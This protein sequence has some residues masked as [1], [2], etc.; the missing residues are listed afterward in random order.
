MPVKAA[1]SMIL[2]TTLWLPVWTRQSPPAQQSPQMK[3]EC[4]DL[5]A[6][7][8]YIAADEKVVD[9]KACH[10]VSTAK[11]IPQPRGPQ[12]FSDGA[13]QFTYPAEYEIGT[14]DSGGGLCSFESEIACVVFPAGR[15]R[16]TTFAGAS[17]DESQIQE[18]KTKAQCLEFSDFYVAGKDPLKNINHV[19][20][21]HRTAASAA[22]GTVTEIDAYRAF[23]EGKC[24]EL[25][26]NIAATHIQ[27]YDPGAIQEFT[28]ADEAQ[29]RKELTAILESFEF[30]K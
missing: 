20:F 22:M 15:F 8:Y 11:I 26:I 9:G 30:T 16:G 13:S 19:T 4:R 3:T 1:L 6:R 12:I 23:H 17:F 21:V 5:A 28:E 7:G 2:A 29:V 14:N 27:S 24:Y 25:S 10:Q 18:A